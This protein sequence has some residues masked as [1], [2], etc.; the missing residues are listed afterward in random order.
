MSS[1]QKNQSVKAIHTVEEWKSVIDSSRDRL[2]IVKVGLKICAPCKKIQPEFESLVSQLDSSI[3]VYKVD[4]DDN[5]LNEVVGV[6]K[7]PTFVAF[8]NGKQMD[9]Y[10]G[11]QPLQLKT[12][13][14]RVTK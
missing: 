14:T 1:E 13:L 2:V 5:A 7:V 12:W 4:V 6:N 9:S 11:A 8:R 10:Q 3:R